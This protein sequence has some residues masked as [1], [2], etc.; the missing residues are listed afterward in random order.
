MTLSH[1]CILHRC[2]PPAPTPRPTSCIS[3]CRQV[4][5][6]VDTPLHVSSATVSKFPLSSPTCCSNN[7]WTNK[8][9]GYFQT[10]YRS[11]TQGCRWTASSSGRQQ[12]LQTVD[13]SE[14]WQ[15]LVLIWSAA[16]MDSE[17]ML[18]GNSM[19]I[20]TSDT[21]NGVSNVK[22]EYLNSLFSTLYLS[23]YIYNS[24]QQCC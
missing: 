20:Q 10:D 1:Q 9:K 21:M 6:A 19:L 23:I 15:V 22:W 3:S 12:V 11:W 18:L 17:D 16:G 2:P 24:C 13:R 5:V 8:H 7:S 14:S 4:D